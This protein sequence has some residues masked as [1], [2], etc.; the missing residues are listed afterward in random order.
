[1]HTIT[2][3]Y[4]SSTFDRD[5]TVA[6]VR[7]YTVRY[8]STVPLPQIVC[9]VHMEH[10]PIS[11]SAS[12]QQ[13]RSASYTATAQQQPAAQSSGLS[14][15]VYFPRAPRRVFLARTGHRNTQ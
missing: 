15:S 3:Y 10:Y 4:C 13:L 2:T 6:V 1:M 12:R 8:G 7:I 9:R 14:Q 11:P 5:R